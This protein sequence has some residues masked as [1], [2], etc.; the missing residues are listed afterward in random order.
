M[1]KKVSEH[2]VK[3]FKPLFLASFLMVV[4]LAVNILFDSCLQ[5]HDYDDDDY[6]PAN[7]YGSLAVTTGNSSNRALCVSDIMAADVTVSGTGFSPISQKNVLISGG[8]SSSA[9]KIEKIPVGNN[10]VVSVEA[11]TNI[12]NILSKMAGV[13]MTSVTNITSG[14]NSVS[15]N[16]ENSK[17]GNVFESLLALG[18]DVSA[19]DALA[20][21]NILPDTHASLIDSSK[22]AAR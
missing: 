1:I 17:L 12:D 15:V 16:W 21:K 6:T 10:R 22:L 4:A 7:P 13:K 9:V 20:I 5:I 2:A 19:L 3:F 18:Y 8:V 11:K 14:D